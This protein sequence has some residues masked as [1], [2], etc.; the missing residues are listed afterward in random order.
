MIRTRLIWGNSILFAIVLTLIGSTVYLT[1]RTSL[2]RS[3]DADLLRRAEFLQVGWGKPPGPDHPGGRPPWDHGHGNGPPPEFLNGAKNLDPIQEKRLEFG[4]Q[5]T[6]PR[7]I[8]RRTDPNEGRP[9]DTP[10]DRFSIRYALIGESVFSDCTLLGHRIRVLTLPLKEAGRVDAVAQFA[11]DLDDI[12]AAVVRLRNVLL[13]M[14][15]LS[16]IVTW[17]LGIWLT[18]RSLRPVRA[19]TEAAEQIEATRLS[20]RL[21]VQ[22]NDEFAILS[23]RFN[24]MLQRIEVSFKTLEDAYEAQRRFVADASHELK[25]PLTTVKGRVGVASRGPQT[26]ERYAEHMASIGRAADQMSAII[27]DLLLLASSDESRLRVEREPQS[28][29]SLAEAAI[30]ATPH[31]GC[32]PISVDIPGDLVVDV[33]GE[34]LTRALGNLL[35]N[36]VRHT[37]REKLIAILAVEGDAGVRIDVADQ[38]EGIPTE[39]VQKVFERFH[40]VDASRHR[41][42]G[43]TGLGLAIV[44]SI[45]EA[46]GGTVS[47]ASV[48]GEGTTV[49][50]FLPN[51]PHI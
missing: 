24:S 11:A 28:L 41:G 22:G 26:L 49:S 29:S 12:D 23:Q 42:S 10:F 43:G 45:V 19:I 13:A 31:E 34:L 20:D 7:V 33:D 18:H 15:P 25:T 40:R 16:L 47:I 8:P 50:I 32:S 27:Q 51:T 38:G 39:H 14:L 6:R 21:P 9:V 3:V 48:L 4:A 1:T 46:H 17:L 35:G 36:A 2:Y 37:P 5:L 44:K 30:R